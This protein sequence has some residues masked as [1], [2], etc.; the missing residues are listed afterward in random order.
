MDSAGSVDRIAELLASVRYDIDA[1]VPD[2]EDRAEALEQ[3]RTSR[4]NAVLTS[5]ADLE[6]AFRRLVR[7]K[8][9]RICRKLVES[10]AGPLTPS[11]DAQPTR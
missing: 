6:A 8:P 1:R 11:I 5:D 7:G 10:A 2:D 9:D 4:F 3:R